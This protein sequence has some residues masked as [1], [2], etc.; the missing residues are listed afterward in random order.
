MIEKMRAAGFREF[1]AKFDR[2]GLIAAL[3]A[4]TADWAQ[5]A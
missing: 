5:A 3:K 2:P 4:I 1:V